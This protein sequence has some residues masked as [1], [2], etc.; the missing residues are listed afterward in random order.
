MKRIIQLICF[1]FCFNFVSH[2]QWATLY[3]GG[4]GTTNKLEEDW[5][6]LFHFSGAPGSNNNV[7]LSGSWDDS[8]KI[9][10]LYYLSGFGAGSAGIYKQ[11]IGLEN[12]AS[13]RVY[14]EMDLPDSVGTI[15]Y[16]ALTD[17]L[18]TD[19]LNNSLCDEFASNQLGTTIL[20]SNLEGH[21]SLYFYADLLR[22]DSV[23]LSFNYVRIEV[24][25]T[26]M[27]NVTPLSNPVPII[28]SSVHALHI[29]L[30]NEGSNFDVDLYNALGISVFE[31]SF[32]GKQTVPLDLE[33]GTYIVQIT[34][35][36]G[37]ISRKK[38]SIE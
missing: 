38:V 37:R 12:Y 23:W 32:M 17:E 22:G 10:M 36:S 30:G 7:A 27:L 33:V 2:S 1:I 11:I 13:V 4:F 29:D 28:Y 16:A 31:D 5:G 34:D 21:T 15:H 25:T 19:S 8:N 20:Y 9:S 35:H 14:L 6:K 24:D 26:Q 18:F 3:E